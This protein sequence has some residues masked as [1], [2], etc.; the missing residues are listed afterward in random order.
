[1]T[2]KPSVSVKKRRLASKS[3]RVEID[4]RDLARP[5]GLA[6]R[7]GM[8]GAVAHEGE[9][10]AVR[11]LAAEAVAAA[12][13]GEPCGRADRDAG[14]RHRAVQRIDAGAVG[15]VEHDADDRG[16]RPAMQADDVMIGRRC[17]G[18][19]ACRSAT[20]PAADPRRSR[21]TGRLRRNCVATSSTLRT[22]RIRHC[23]MVINPPAATSPGPTPCR[24]P[25]CRHS[26]A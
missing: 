26:P 25:S 11:I 20:A 21:R 12:V 5:V 6:L 1:M 18:R 9:V 10:A 13:R 3:L 23:D 15:H 16:L 24:N 7:V 19:A 22:P 2:R 17:R 14:R 8:I 4:V